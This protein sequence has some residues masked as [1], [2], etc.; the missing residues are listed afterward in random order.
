MSSRRSFLRHAA[1]ASAASVIVPSGIAAAA[2]SREVL[3][4]AAGRAGRPLPVPPAG[5]PTQVAQDE[6]YWREIAAQFAITDAVTN[7]EAGFWGMM[8]APVLAAYHRNVDHVNR[9]SSYFARR[10]YPAIFGEVRQQV[11][12]TLGVD[13]GEI[14]FARNATEALQSVIGQY[15]R[16]QP[17]D[18]VLYADLDYPAMQM[19]MNAL[20]ERRGARVVTIDLPEP[21]T[22]ESL[23]A[24]YT[25]ALD[26]HPR[27]RLLLL[28]HPNNKNG[29]MLPLRAITDLAR[30]RG[31]D[32]VLD[33]AH[34]VGQVPLSLPETGA[35]FG[36]VNL[37]KWV[38]A[39]IGVAALYIRKD[40]LDRID[41]AHGDDGPLDRIDSRIHTGT[42]DF[43]AVMTVS[44]ALAFQD[45]I[46]IP[47]KAARLRYLRD[48]WVKPARGIPGV[49]V[50]TPDDPA[51]GGA[52]ASFRLHG[53]GD[54]AYNAGVA[55]RLVEE[56]GIFT[57]ARSGL[58]K[59]DCVRV[60]PALYS[61]PADTAKFVRALR[62][63]A[64]RG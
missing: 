33:A 9:E 51:L 58:A 36:G 50:I 48:T 7:L 54:R 5:T 57:V 17:G 13:A 31:V 56:F 63:L 21:A 64:A 35:T 27:T 19:A 52:I 14:A 29:L 6:A 25:R 38:A 37:H 34:A 8:A 26:A 12:A 28:T 45:R 61:T 62:V 44:D 1:V 20:A 11:A 18:T 10:E 30:A 23:I 39:P 32:T 3:E 4:L 16:L 24:A 53:N 60:T 40:A 15:N 43:A 41:R 46:G 47:R 2:P 55:R 42:T 49:D 22:R 59:G